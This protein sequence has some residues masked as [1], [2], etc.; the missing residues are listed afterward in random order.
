MQGSL[1]KLRGEPCDPVRYHLRV[2]GDEWDLNALLG[3]RLALRFDGEIRCVACGRVTRRSYR[4]G[5]CYPCSRRLARCDLCILRPELCHF[6]AGTCREPEWGLEHCMRGHLV[7]LANA[8]G[9]KVGITREGREQRRWIDQGAVQ[10]VAL[11]RARSRYLAGLAESALRQHV[12]DRTDWR[13]MLRGTPPPVDL[14]AHGQRLL[15]RTRAELEQIRGEHGRDA[16][17]P[18]RARAR[19][20]AYPVAEYP[21]RVRS[22]DLEREGAIRSALRGIKGQ[23]LILDDGVLNVRKFTGY[24]VTARACGDGR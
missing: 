13:R 4:Q 8:S 22:L 5:Y 20:I 23:Y 24:C 19:R 9:L 1:D 15:R 2:G 12:S 7:Y 14:Q 17:V 21:G 10:G 3:R 18:V 16:L 11:L 6:D